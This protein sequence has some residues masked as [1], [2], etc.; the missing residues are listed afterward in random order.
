METGKKSRYIKY[1]IGEIILVM[2]GILLALQVNT[3]SEEQKK[4]KLKNEYVTSLITDF[5]K[6]TVQIN[7]RL[8]L[9][10]QMLEDLV[11]IKDTI[12]SG[13]ITTTGDFKALYKNLIGIGI[14][15]VNTYNTNSFNLLISSGN[16]DLLDKQL[17]ENIMELNRLQN[18]E[19]GI[20]TFNRDYFTKFMENISIKYPNPDNPFYTDV[21]GDL[22]WK[23]TN[24]EELPKDIIS[25][26]GQKS[27]TIVRYI[28]LTEN[29]ILQT[30]V[31]LEQLHDLNKNG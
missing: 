29:V 27:Y 2:I 5:T 16:I 22:L 28:E 1:A 24:I 15:L 17:R 25:F 11:K 10:K 18:Y 12:E 4:N 14:R 30:E 6:D 21:I 19:K 31:V 9:N 20:T 26:L 8:K 3:W 13:Y 7:A 23:S